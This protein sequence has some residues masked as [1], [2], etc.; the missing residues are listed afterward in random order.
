MYDFSHRDYGEGVFADFGVQ[1]FTYGFEQK[2]YIFIFSFLLM[3]ALDTVCSSRA[4]SF[5]HE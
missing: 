3:L 5:V 4:H 2:R 1:T